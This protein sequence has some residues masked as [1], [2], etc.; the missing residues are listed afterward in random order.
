MD[1]E[2]INMQ[3]KIAKLNK[4]I[5]QLESKI[6]ELEEDLRKRKHGKSKSKN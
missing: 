4:L 5:K 3:G 6:G 1:Q 2:K